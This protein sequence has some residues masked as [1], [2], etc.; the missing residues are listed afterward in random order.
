[1]DVVVV[2]SMFDVDPRFLQALRVLYS[3]VTE[4]VELDG[5][6]QTYQPKERSY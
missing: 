6:D 5:H 1:M 2:V 3:F 4:D